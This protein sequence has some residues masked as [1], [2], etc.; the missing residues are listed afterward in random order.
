MKITVHTVYE[1]DDPKWFEWYLSRPFPYPA[2][3]A[4]KK[5]RDGAAAASFSTFDGKAHAA[6][7]YTYERETSK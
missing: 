4:I 6:T 2:D 5:I 7:T 1:S 3:E